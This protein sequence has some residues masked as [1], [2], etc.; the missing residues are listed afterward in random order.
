MKSQL[1][2]RSGSLKLVE[3]TNTKK[4]CLGRL[5]GPC[6]DCFNATRNGRKYGLKLWQNVFNNDLVKEALATHTLFGELDH[7]ED[8]FECESKYACICMTDY[9]I[10]E[11]NG[12]VYGGFDILDTPQGRILKSLVDYGSQMGVSSRGEGDIIQG[13]DG[14][15]VDPDTYE[16]SCFDVVSTPAVKKARQTVVESMEQNRK[17][18]NLLESIQKEINDATDVNVLNGIETTITKAEVPNLSKLQ[19]SIKNRKSQLIER[20]TISSNTNNNA[21]KQKVENRKTIVEDYENLISTTDLTRK[22]RAYKLREK[23]LTKTINS[24]K[25]EINQLKSELNNSTTALKESNQKRQQV[26]TDNK[27]L[28]SKLSEQETIN[29]LLE[30]TKTKLNKTIK[31]GTV[32]NEKYQ[33]QLNCNKR[34][35]RSN[36]KLQENVSNLSE[37]LN[38]SNEIIESYKDRQL[39][40][41]EQI[42]SLQEQLDTQRKNTIIQES[43]ISDNENAYNQLDESYTDLENKYNELLEKFNQLEATNTELKNSNKTIQEKLNSSIKLNKQY[44]QSFLKECAEVKGINPDSVLLKESI[45]T[46]NQ[47]K[48][49]VKEAK[50]KQDRFSKL[51]ISYESP[52]TVKILTEDL[53]KLD[54]EETKLTDFLMSVQ[55]MF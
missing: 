12:I 45:T 3:S 31:A 22:I 19:N 27:T 53:N 7:P 55:T 46:P 52:T 23:Q 8:R 17:K 50:D 47:I 38:A 36:S 41:K 51:P 11:D 28:T 30:D 5:E 14:E 18:R 42:R 49:L 25:E 43:L 9:R 48:Q 10:D 24:Y 54:E 33:E 26:V 4:G 1:V 32:L 2:E 6:A 39:Q 34:L 44:T 37:Q 20:K 13:N 29:T 40:L 16:F 15:E 21:V 35:E